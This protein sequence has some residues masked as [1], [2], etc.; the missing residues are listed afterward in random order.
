M[1]ARRL[2]RRLTLIAAG[3]AA[4]AIASQASAQPTD[5]VPGVTYERVAGGGQVTHVTR[6]DPSPLISFRPVPFNGTTARRGLLTTMMRQRLGS[7]AVAGVNGDFFNWDS[8]FPSGLFVQDGQFVNEPE[9]TRSAMVLTSTGALMALQSAVQ[10]T[11]QADPTP[12]DPLVRQGGFVAANRPAERPS[13]DRTILY[14]SSFGDLTPRSADRVE[15]LITLD[16]PGVIVP[17]R[18]IAGT[19]HSVRSGGGSGV[20][21]RMVALTGVGT[22]PAARIGA[23]TPG[24]RITLNPVLTNLPGDVV[25]AMG[26]GPVLVQ[27][28]QAVMNGDATGFTSGQVAGRSARTAIGQTAQGQLLMVVT[29]G[30]LEGSVGMT[31]NEQANL[32]ASLGAQTAIAMD[33]GGS[34]GMAIRERLVNRVGN[35]ERA[36]ANG[37]IVSYGGV[38]LTEPAA[39][40]SPNGDRVDDFTRVAARS[41][42]EGAANIILRNA[43]GKAVR[44]VYR[45]PLGPAGRIITLSHRLKVPAGRYTLVAQL[46]PTDGSTPTEHVRPLVIDP[47]LG[48]LRLRK[49]GP[50]AKRTLNIGFRLQSNA[51]VTAVVRD[52]QGR[53]VKLVTRNR[54][55]KRGPRTLTYDMLRHRKRLAPG[56][57]TVT[58]GV[59]TNYGVKNE[60]SARFRVT[61]PP[62]AP[63][64][65][66]AKAVRR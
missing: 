26:G 55:L 61:K 46:R 18:P 43:S 63:A 31:A 25:A 22:N 3:T 7:G 24:R 1:Q 27:N 10:G 13:S 39:F 19:V 2:T 47:T 15:A 54:L 23:L 30:P 29:E 60:L 51:R 65:P 16:A 14:T 62:K 40:I 5:V 33:S 64:T 12:A 48:H 17:N 21:P 20:A 66:R 34:S 6:V 35:G 9:A 52:T 50:T 59:R 11:W 49:V 38:Q 44:L 53:S 8:G 42:K 36:V 45:G 37:L 28:G 41:A 58:V 4:A 32:M 57:Y 56:V